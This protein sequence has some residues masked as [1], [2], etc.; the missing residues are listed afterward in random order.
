MLT[1]TTVWIYRGIYDKRSA[2]F[3]FCH[4]SLYKCWVIL[5]YTSYLLSLCSPALQMTPTRITL[6]LSTAAASHSSTG[7]MSQPHG[8][9]SS[10]GNWNRYRANWNSYFF[11]AATLKLGWFEENSVVTSGFVPYLTYDPSLIADAATLLKKS[12][13]GSFI[14]HAILAW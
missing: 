10:C 4:Y 8:P 3:Y 13:K 12:T 6:S 9:S 7:P 1:F 5:R 14:K 2:E 11:C